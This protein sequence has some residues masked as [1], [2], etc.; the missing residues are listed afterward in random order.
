MIDRRVVASRGAPRTILM[1]FRTHIRSPL[2]MALFT[3]VAVVATAA[4]SAMALQGR[5]WWW[6]WRLVA[7]A[8]DTSD[9]GDAGRSPSASAAVV[10]AGENLPVLPGDLIPPGG[11]V[12]SV[13]PSSL[14]AARFTTPPRRISVVE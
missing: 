14:A 12:A 1:P 13:A 3:L 6:W 10:L 2:V 5:W 8:S 7:A 9:A 11:G 4:V